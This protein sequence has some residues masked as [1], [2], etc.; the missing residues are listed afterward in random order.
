MDSIRTFLEMGGY[1]AFVWPAF[2][3]TFAVLAGMLIVTLRT[4][5]R[6]EAALAALQ[7]HDAVAP[8]AP[9]PT[10]TGS[11]PSTEREARA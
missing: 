9:G 10:G 4:L 2:A 3:V 11:R 8:E 5:R 7:R 1:A 6:R